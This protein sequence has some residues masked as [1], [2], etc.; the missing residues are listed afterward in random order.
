MVVQLKE[1]IRGVVGMSLEMEKG[2][3]KARADAGRM[4]IGLGRFPR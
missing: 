4:R 2:E 3:E 1:G